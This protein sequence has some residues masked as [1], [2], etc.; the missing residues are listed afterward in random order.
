[1]IVDIDLSCKTVVI[2]GGGSQAERRIESLLQEECKRI[3][4]ISASPASNRIKKW[5][6]TK[7]IRWSRR[8]IRDESFMDDYKPDIVIAAT[9]SPEINSMAVKA[10][11]KRGVLAYRSDDH[12]QRDFSHPALIR[13]DGKITVAIF[14]GGQSPA[15]SKDIRQKAEPVLRGIVTQEMLARMRIQDTI[16][17]KAKLTIPT[18]AERKELLSSIMSD[19]TVDRLIR[20]GLL[21]EAEK[22]AM[23]MLRDR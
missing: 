9:D 11:R 23:S 13:L 12:H 10:A 2:I 19:K 21:A 16:R 14:T 17:Q 3:I 4:V 8:D 5:S 18:Q 20:D 6:E 22:L 7:G 1:M 15:I